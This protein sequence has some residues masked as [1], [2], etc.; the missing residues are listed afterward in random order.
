MDLQTKKALRTKKYLSASFRRYIT[1]KIKPIKIYIL[2]G[3]G[4]I[5][6]LNSLELSEGLSLFVIPSRIQIISVIL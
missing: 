4:S 6:F 3:T 1:D 2:P 5:I